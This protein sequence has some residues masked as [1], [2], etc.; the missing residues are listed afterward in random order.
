MSFVAHQIPL[1]KPGVHRYGGEVNSGIHRYG[2]EVNPDGIDQ[3]ERT[4]P[5]AVQ[6]S[7]KWANEWCATGLLLKIHGAETDFAWR[8]HHLVLDDAITVAKEFQKAYTECVYRIY[9]TETGDFILA[10]LLQ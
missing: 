4:G 2:R 6:V 7:S 5:W 1:D 10:W 9:N 3:P 8:S